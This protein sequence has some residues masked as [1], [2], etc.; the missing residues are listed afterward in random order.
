MKNIKPGFSLIELSIA[1]VIASML[2][3][4][5]YRL[6]TQASTF[7]STVSAVVNYDIPLDS[8]FNQVEK[9][10]MGIFTPFSMQKEL[11]E[12]DT[13]NSKEQNAQKTDNVPAADKSTVDKTDQNSKK[14]THIFYL[15]QAG[16]N[17]FL[18]FLTT[19]GLQK[20]SNKG[21]IETRSLLKRVVYRLE[22][23]PE[24]PSLHSL[25]YTYSSDALD[26]ETLK[27]KP[28][29]SYYLML[30]FIKNFAI[31]TT[32]YMA[33]EPGKKQADTPEKISNWEEKEIL[34][35][36]KTAIPAYIG[37]SGSLASPFDKAEQPFE[38][39][40]KVPAYQVPITKKTQQQPQ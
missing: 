16:R 33:T 2:S 6:V 29:S 35:K 31:T 9:D 1:L 24:D 10:I 19:G 26:L 18:S 8:F 7:V 30:E 21:I 5:I 40:F 37:I 36:Y 25:Y 15:E 17:I 28:L 20:I 23:S 11:Q 14:L 12:R 13:N 4:T 3:I 27:K 38:F 39:L 32:V 22:Q 34:E